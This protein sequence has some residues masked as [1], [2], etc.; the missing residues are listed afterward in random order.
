MKN[1]HGFTLLEALLYIGLFSIM[2]TGAFAGIYAISESA[3]RNQTLSHLVFEGAFLLDKVALAV[4]ESTS[5]TITD[6]GT[7]LLLNSDN[8]PVTFE[9]SSGAMTITR[10]DSLDTRLSDSSITVSELIFK[11][12]SRGAGSRSVQISFILSAHTPQG[13]LVQQNFSDVAYFQL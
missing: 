10:S 8:G 11:M 4:A 6:S 13:Q 3:Q 1:S 9:S 7:S 5:S 12:G 2:M